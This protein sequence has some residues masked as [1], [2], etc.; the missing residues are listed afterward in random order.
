MKHSI[1]ELLKALTKEISEASQ[2]IG[3]SFNLNSGV[4]RLVSQIQ[5]AISDLKAVNSMLTEIRVE[6]DRLSKKV[7]AQLGKESFDIAGKYGKAATDYLAGVQK[8]VR[9]GHQ[10]VSELAELSLAAQ[11]AGNMTA[12]L[13]ADLT[14]RMILTTDKAYKMNG[15][16]ANLTK[17]LDG[18]NQISNKN[19]VG[20][21]DLSEGLSSISQTAATLGVDAG[22]ATAA[23]GTMMETT[24][25]GSAQAANALETILLYTRQVS[26]A[27]KG[28]SAEGLS[29]Y[30][31]ACN[32]LNVRLRETRDG[33]VGLRDPMEVLGELSSAYNKLGDSSTR[34]TNLLDSLGGG[35]TAA[36]MDALLSQWSTYESMLG[37]YKS[38]AGSMARD[39]EKLADSWEGA[40]N[41]L[42]NTLT[43]TISNIVNSDAVIAVTNG[44]DGILSVVNK[45]TESLGSLG[46]IGVGAGLFA[47]LKNVGRVKRNPS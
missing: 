44:L 38:G 46:T 6:N 36:Q 40:S 14:E 27:G 43:S 32:A 17:V 35:Q 21:A 39:A 8:M 1:D 25:A 47:G 12:D 31:R 42:Y 19:N 22:E 26:D 18:M 4:K 5:S 11:N 3:K 16:V 41:R 37:Q 28:V 7:L 29:A 9:A 34:K 10:N 30:E 20:L 2:T 23:L 15:S 45:V 33:V 24:Q 13:T